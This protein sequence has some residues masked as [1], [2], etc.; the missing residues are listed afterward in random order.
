MNQFH[1]HHRRVLEQYSKESG[2]IFYRQVMGDG[3]AD[4]HYGIYG[5]SAIEM[6]DATKASTARLFELA[7]QQLGDDLPREVIDLGAGRGGAA[8]EIAQ[9]TGAKVVCV[10]LCDHHNEA[11]ELQA[12]TIGI[13]QQIETWTCSFER[14]PD[15]WTGRFDLVWSQEAICH[16]A[17]KSAA[18]SEAIRVLRPGGVFAFSDILLVESAPPEEAKAFTSLNAVVQL[19]T[20]AEYANHLRNVGVVDITY[21]DWTAHLPANFASMRQK[22]RQQYTNLVRQG[23]AASFLDQFA[24][25]LA[26]RLL[27]PTGAVMQWGAFCCRKSVL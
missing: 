17:D 26:Q 1:D 7:T 10:E 8:Q 12:S 18:I 13:R 4:I 21:E 27:W 14:L 16:A 19:S 3:G 9:R 22:I 2:A 25:A 6:Q 23:V 11:N 5:P 20:H 15:N 24:A